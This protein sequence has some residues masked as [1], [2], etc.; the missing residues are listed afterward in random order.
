MVTEAQTREGKAIQ[1]R[2]GRTFH[3]ATRF[4]PARVRRPTYVLYAFFRIADEVVDDPTPSSSEVQRE[5]LERIRSV[6]LGKEPP[7]DEPILEAFAEIREDYGIPDTEVNAFIDAMVEDI[8]G[9]GP[10]TYEDLEEYMRGSAVAV[11]LMMCAIMQPADEQAAAPHARALGEAF[12][13][14]NFLRDVREDVAEYGRV[15]LPEETLAAHGLTP[16]SIIPGR[17]PPGL[18]GVMELELERAEKKYRHGVAGIRYLPADCRFP[19]LLA[20]VLYAEYHA[21]IRA[22]DYDVLKTRPRLGTVTAMMLLVRTWLAY[23][24]SDDPEETFYRVSAL[25]RESPNQSGS[26]LRKAVT[27]SLRAPKLGSLLTSVRRK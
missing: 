9:D 19:V 24:R 10:D 15:Y 25:A 18:K 13:L 1:R 4:L 20:A 2:T 23:H 5:R 17:S 8:E 14:T 7:E 3:L 11:G 12:Q 21:K 27:R 6:A 16:A 22:I 26:W